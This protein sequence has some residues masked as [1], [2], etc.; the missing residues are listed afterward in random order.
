[1][2]QRDLR[3]TASIDERYDKTIIVTL[4]FGLPGL[5]K[6]TLWHEIKKMNQE[7]NI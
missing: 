2:E 7:T 6:T 4:F 1:M 3:K 5:G